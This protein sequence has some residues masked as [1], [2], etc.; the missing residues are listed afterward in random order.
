MP[1][2]PRERAGCGRMG[3]YALVVALEEQ[4]VIDSADATA[5]TRTTVYFDGPARDCRAAEENL[6]PPEYGETFLIS[7]TACVKS[8]AWIGAPFLH[9][10]KRR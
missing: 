5:V 1:A 8:P 3:A 10:S 7:P 9:G 4:G 6:N 2:Q